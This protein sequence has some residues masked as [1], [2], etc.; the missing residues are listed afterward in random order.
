MN[1]FPGH[2]QLPV[3]HT[4]LQTL[5]S[6]VRGKGTTDSPSHMGSLFCEESN[7]GRKDQDGAP[8]PGKQISL[9]QFLRLGT[10]METKNCILGLIS[11]GP[12]MQ[13]CPE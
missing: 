2:I 6:R 10:C 1:G 4:G 12:P 9:V 8:H 3:G 11:F 5:L 7:D 13:L